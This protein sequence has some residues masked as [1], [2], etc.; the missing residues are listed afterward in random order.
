MENLIVARQII[1]IISI[2]SIISLYP[3]RLKRELQKNL[4]TPFPTEPTKP[5]RVRN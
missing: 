2:S 3:I 4:V 1:L 5:T